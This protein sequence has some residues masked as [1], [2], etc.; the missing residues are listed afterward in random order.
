[1]PLPDQSPIFSSLSDD[2]D[3]LEL[4]EEFVSNLQDRMR[5]LEALVNVNDVGE[6]ARLAHQ[7]KGTSGSYGFRAISEAAA[8]LEQSA[9]VADSV[10]NVENEVKELISFCQRAK[11]VPA[12]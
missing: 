9:K 6:L 10:S 12:S 7:L 3:M 1:M 11:A 5:S 4:I 2:P 8:R